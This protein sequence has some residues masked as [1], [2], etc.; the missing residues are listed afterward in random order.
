MDKNRN[1]Y[2]SFCE[3]E[4]ILRDYLALDRT[5]LA[6]ERTF[7]SYTRTAMALVIAGVTF[8]KF[9]DSLAMTI[10][11]LICVPIGLAVF[12]WG[13]YRYRQIHERI[14]AIA[15]TP[16]NKRPDYIKAGPV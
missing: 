10:T 6:N 3:E 9:F 5:V 14:H 4:M 2:C 8:I 7:L 12:A 1:P 16:A 13:L 11:G 15:A